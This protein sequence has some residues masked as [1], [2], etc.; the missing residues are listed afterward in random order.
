MAVE[1]RRPK[2]TIRI[3]VDAYAQRTYAS[4]FI[5]TGATVLNKCVLMPFNRSTIQCAGTAEY[6][7]FVARYMDQN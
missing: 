5:M 4:L 2:T 7:G 1:L 3:L 6:D